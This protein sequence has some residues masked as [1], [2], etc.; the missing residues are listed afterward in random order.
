MPDMRG[1]W[2]RRLDMS[3]QAASGRGMC[4]QRKDSCVTG[5]TALAF[6][7]Y[8]KCFDPS[9]KF[10]TFG[11]KCD[12]V[13]DRC[14]SFLDEGHLA[15]EVFVKSRERERERYEGSLLMLMDDVKTLRENVWS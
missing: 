8:K 3:T 13:K 5:S 1:A 12:L 2:I 7:F 11:Q 10:P 6:P 4:R 14:R 9:E 15:H